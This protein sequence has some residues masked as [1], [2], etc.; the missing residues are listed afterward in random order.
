MEKASISPISAFSTLAV[1]KSSVSQ[2]S[3]SYIFGATSTLTYIDMLK[4][5]EKERTVNRNLV[6]DPEKESKKELN[7]PPSSTLSGAKGQ[8]IRDDLS[9]SDTGRN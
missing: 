7:I 9:L 2:I 3:A 6:T 5:K 4:E 8:E 1:E